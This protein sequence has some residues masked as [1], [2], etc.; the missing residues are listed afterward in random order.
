M[1]YLTRRKE[2]CCLSLAAKRVDVAKLDELVSAT[3]C[4]RCC[5]LRSDYLGYRYP[6]RRI[7]GLRCCFAEPSDRCCI[8]H[9]HQGKSTA[10]LHRTY[11]VMFS[12]EIASLPNPKPARKGTAASSYC[13]SRWLK[14][15]S[16]GPETHVESSIPSGA[17]KFP[18]NDRAENLTLDMV[19][20]LLD[21]SSWTLLRSRMN[22]AS[23][24]ALSLGSETIMR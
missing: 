20:S 18:P 12:R 21:P 10:G 2:S 14:T 6:I 7:R 1:G 23:K 5:N 8:G 19:W 13:W 16:A 15:S 3:Q 11:E 9:Q 24:F 17:P 22:R 4:P